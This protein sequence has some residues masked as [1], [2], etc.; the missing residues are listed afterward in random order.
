MELAYFSVV[1][2]LLSA[3]QHGLLAGPLWKTYLAWVREGR[4]PLRWVE[5]SLSA[6][7]MH[8]HVSL[9]CGIYDVHILFLIGGLTAVTMLFGLFA[10]ETRKPS[11]FLAGFFPYL[12]GWVVIACYFFYSVS[13][14]N[15]VPDFVWS[16]F[17][18][19]TILDLSF[20]V[21]M[22]LNI[23]EQRAF[24]DFRFTEVGYVVLSLTSKQFLAWMN[25]YGSKTR[26]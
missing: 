4:N 6:S 8:I 10:E 23:Y 1:F 14:S 19:I 24:R 16:I 25:F 9:L 13:K 11:V 20:A 21:L 2:L 17:F 15:D 3:I 7:V 5:Y 18:I 12:F 26:E 22:G